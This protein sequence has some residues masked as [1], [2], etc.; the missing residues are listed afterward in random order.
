MELTD[1]LWIP[2]LCTFASFFT[3]W[4][5][6]ANDCANSFATSVGAKVLTLRQAVL[7]AAIFEFTGAFLMGSH[8]TD[9]VRKKIVDNSSFEEHPEELMWGMFCAVFAA[10]IWLCIA[11]KLKLPVSTTHSIV[12]AIVGFGLAAEGPSVV[13][14][15][16]I[17]E[18][19]VSWVLSPLISGL[20]A[21]GIFLF[22]KYFALVKENPIKNLY[23]IYP[24]LIFCLFFINALFIIYKGTPALNLDNTP[25]W[26]SV[27]SS[28]GIGIFCALIG[29]FI[30]IPFMK[31]R[32]EVWNE[33][34]ENQRNDPEQQEIE[35]TFGE[36][37]TNKT[38][39]ILYNNEVNRK[40]NFSKIN[41]DLQELI[42]IDNYE[43]IEK[44]YENAAV[45]DE[46]SEKLCSYLQ[47]I[48]ACFASFAHG[49]NDVANSIAPLAACWA[50]YNSGSIDST[51]TVP[52]WILAMGGV[53]IVIGLSTWGYKVIDRIGKELTKVTPSRGFPME[54]GPAIT[55]LLASRLEI[56]VSTTHCQIGSVFGVGLLDGVKNV[57]F[58]SLGKIVLSWIVTLPVTGGISAALYSL[59]HYAP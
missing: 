43:R 59:G 5:I 13:D 40:D 16:T 26:I 41:S 56:P 8:V 53:G 12:G 38:R 22:I 11:T 20:F 29:Q 23:K 48:T 45:Y 27:V 47:I 57:D 25:L 55:V 37:F 21:V 3:S 36:Q 14:W 4:G 33:N 51:V 10:G 24:F 50:I 30:G 1:Y 54:M 42:Q 15:G 9:T 44:S 49:S 7:V 28:V 39:E 31:K 35:L 17:G 19:V 46:S 18:I 6:G 2:I 58:T 34:R 52:L 32:L